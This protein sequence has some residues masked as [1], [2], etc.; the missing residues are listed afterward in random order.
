[1]TANFILAILGAVFAIGGLGSFY[2][3]QRTRRLSQECRDWPSARGKVVVSEVR[4]IDTRDDEGK[5]ST[6][7]SP[8]IEYEYTVGSETHRGS[9]IQFGGP[10]GA[11]EAGA[12]S[13]VERYPLGAIVDVAYDPAAPERCTLE[14]E[15]PRSSFVGIMV[16]TVFLWGLSALLF[17][18]A[19]TAEVTPR[20]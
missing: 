10:W 8:R 11:T 9:R 7:Y 15:T 3:Y 20:R 12:S 13:Y 14:R 6:D 2:W 4:E 17:L 19:I 18:L 16:L 1:M 5:T